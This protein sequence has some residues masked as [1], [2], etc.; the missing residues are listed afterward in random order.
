MPD[1]VPDVTGRVS[2]IQQITIAWMCLEAG[3]SLW[4]AMRAKSPAL[5]A[6]G[7]DSAVELLSAVVVWRRFQRNLSDE[8]A[9]R[10][11]A[12][13]AATLLIILAIFV[14]ATSAL[15]LLGY[16][17]PGPSYVGVAVL[18]VAAVAGT[19][20]EKVVGRSAK[21]RPAGR[22]G[23]VD[24]VCVPCNHRACGSGNPRGVGIRDSRSDCGPP[25]HPVHIA[26]GSRSL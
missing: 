3:V 25:D 9:E 8:R 23:R 10:R 26:R 16:S 5:L 20:K 13:I 1:A 22:R 24:A 11:A 17:E 12:R 7:G 19:A 18:I 4:A 6:F 2:R 15:S 21:R 14:A